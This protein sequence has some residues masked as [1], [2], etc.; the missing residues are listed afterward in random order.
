M[1]PSTHR[2]HSV[3]LTWRRADLAVLVVLVLGAAVLLAAWGAG[4]RRDLGGEPGGLAQRA[5]RAAERI[6]PNLASA[7]SLRRLPGIGPALARAIVAARGPE[8]GGPF[9]N[10]DDLQARVRGIGPVTARVIAPLL[11]FAPLRR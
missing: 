5:E 2:A 11:T 1:T 3:D 6:D 7:A 4:R 10:V 8:A 9:K